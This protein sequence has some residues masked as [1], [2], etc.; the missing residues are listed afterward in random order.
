MI[1]R[2]VWQNSQKLL[3]KTKVQIRTYR[4]FQIL[5][6]YKINMHKCNLTISFLLP[7]QLC[8]PKKF[9]KSLACQLIA[10]KFSNPLKQCIVSS[11]YNSNWLI[12]QM[13]SQKDKSN[14][15]LT[16]MVTRTRTNYYSN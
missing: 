3:L 10:F 11:L 16:I 12:P 13:F 8:Q 9:S 5:S 1:T 6:R 15:F 7:I 14:L 4:Q 2:Y